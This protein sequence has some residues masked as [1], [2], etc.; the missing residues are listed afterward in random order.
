MQSFLL[1]LLPAVLLGALGLWQGTQITNEKP[2]ASFL[3]NGSMYPS[4]INRSSCDF[5]YVSNNEF[6]PSLKRKKM[7]GC[8][9]NPIIYLKDQIGCKHIPAWG[10]TF[11]TRL[12]FHCNHTDPYLEPFNST[13][14]NCSPEETASLDCDPTHNGMQLSLLADGRVNRL[15]M[16]YSEDSSQLNWMAV[17]ENP[18]YSVLFES[19]S[20]NRVENFFLT[21]TPCIG[22]FAHHQNSF[23]L[24]C[25]GSQR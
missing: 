21:A 11:P 9:A 25:P 16:S 6:R 1:I 12:P 18:H 10:A 22:T 7:T 17:F 19:V 15:K 14:F 2:Y 24:S 8:K 4:C 5:G 20:S 3:V 13:C 23:H